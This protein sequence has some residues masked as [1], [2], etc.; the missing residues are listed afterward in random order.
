[1]P[2][3]HLLLSLL[4]VFG[5]IALA[6]GAVAAGMALAMVGTVYGVLVLS[7]SLNW[8][9]S[10][11]EYVSVRLAR[12][13]RPLVPI[14]RWL[15]RRPWV[16]AA[17]YTSFTPVLAA[18]AVAGY[19]T[20]YVYLDE[21]DVPDVN[22]VLNWQP[23][24]IGRINDRNGRII[25][26]AAKNEYREMV[27]WEELPQVMRDALVA[28]E[29]KRLFSHD[30]W[31]LLATARAG[32][33]ALTTSILHFRRQGAS[34]IPQQDVRRVYPQL[35]DWVRRQKGS[36]L[37]V[38]NI[39]TRLV[40]MEKGPVWTNNVI[41]K[42]REIKYAVRT[43]E[44]LT[45]HL[46]SRRLAKEELLTVYAN[47]VY[48]GH[49]VYGVKYAARFFLDKDLKDLDAAD[50]AFLASLI[51][52]PD[53]YGRLTDDD[54]DMGDKVTRR[55]AVLDRM[56]WNGFITSDRV[57]YLKR[58]PIRL[59]VP[60]L[61]QKTEAPAVVN[62]AMREMEEGGY[63]QHHLHRGD[64]N[65]DL[66][67]DTAIQNAVNVA[68][69]RGINGD[70]AAKIAG[71]KGRFKVRGPL[72]QVA[73]VVLDNRTGAILAMHGGFVG[74]DHRYNYA[75]YNR[76][77]DAHRQ[78]GSTFKIVDLVAATMVGMTPDSIV[79]DV[80]AYVNMGDGTF[81]KVGNYDGKR[82]GPITL[83]LATAESRNLAYLN[84]MREQVGRT[85]QAFVDAALLKAS[86]GHP[87]EPG[88]AEAIRW[89]REMGIKSNLDPY[90][91][92]VLGANG[93]TPLELANAL[94]TVCSGVQAEPY[95]IN[96]VTDRTGAVIYEHRPQTK[97]FPMPHDK[98]E[99]AHELLRGNILLQTG[100]AHSLDTSEF[101]IQLMGKTGT[102]NDHRDAW[103]AGCTYGRSG[104][105][106]VSWV[107]Y[108]DF[109]MSL[110]H[111][112][113]LYSRAS[114]GAVA[115][116]LVRD[117][118]LQVYGAGKPL[119]DPPQMPPEIAERIKAASEKIYPKS[120]S[121]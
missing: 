52:A 46:G 100:T 40:A 39:L 8:A 51:P 111:D 69:W 82:K 5:L 3:W 12:V 112:G 121:K 97:P 117:F 110:P 85:P 103:F 31:D 14:H 79:M 10:A 118:F 84:M 21:S 19:L 104:I 76:A 57:R 93:I 27:T 101:P 25:M 90:I 83:R 75:T 73:F 34:T 32:A 28:A 88:V 7:K 23:P 81:K 72:P 45:K 92:T 62:A 77:I 42:G 29:D 6:V 74:D 95:L 86:I 78:P 109:S 71:F 30:G 119:G 44:G 41:R 9:I 87:V 11:A 36:D 47:V 54:Q 115:L 18:V 94:R 65:L 61:R 53:A 24:Q 20:W 67:T 4:G 107:G 70:P 1:M 59:V 106:A 120:A 37:L 2:N 102:S 114:G 99:F 108:D 98:L 116:P 64:I 22:V 49:G 96:R 58:H 63:T 48:F 56:S 43:E 66:T 33:K 60:D 38:D 26:R 89:A 91:S 50:A 68:A 35:Q 55:N 80:D 113:P 13:F 17:V 105:T 16:R 15:G